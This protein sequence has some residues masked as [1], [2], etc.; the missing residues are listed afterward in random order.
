MLFVTDGNRKSVLGAGRIVHHLQFISVRSNTTR[1]FA[2]RS[3]GEEA[4][5]SLISPV[6]IELLLSVVFF[7]PHANGMRSELI[8]SRALY[9]WEESKSKVTNVYSMFSVP[10]FYR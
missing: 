10:V 7:K 1:L 8:H 6:G 5:L 4:H 2:A 9:T 3:L